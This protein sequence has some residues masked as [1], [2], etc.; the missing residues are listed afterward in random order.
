MQLETP[1]ELDAWIWALLG[2]LMVL[3]V[4]SAWNQGCLGP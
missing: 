1:P 2:V 3:V 4:L